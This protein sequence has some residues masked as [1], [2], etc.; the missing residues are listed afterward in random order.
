V[1]SEMLA[2]ITPELLT[3]YPDQREL[4]RKL[5]QFTSLPEDSLLLTAGSDSA[6]KLVYE[7]F[8]APGDEVVFLEP[9]YAMIEVYADLFEARKQKVG[10]TAQLDLRF[11]ELLERITSKTRVAF[12]ANPNQPSGTVLRN[13]QL[14]ELLERTS[15]TGTLLVMDEAYQHFS[16]TPSALELV[17]NHDNLVVTQTFSKAFGLA[18]VRLGFLAA[19]PAH[20]DQ[21][22]K[23]KPL[24]DINLL[25]VKCGEY[26][27]DHY[28]PI[29]GEYVRSVRQAKV[30]LTR[31]LKT[32]G[33][34]VIPSEANFI[35]FRLGAQD[36]AGRIAAR[37]KERGYLIRTA[38]TGLPAV[39]EGCI[40]ITVGPLEQMKEFL[41][42]FFQVIQKRI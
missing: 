21:L 2:S 10:Y 41:T 4:Y 42:T 25:A 19:H 26:L 6:I 31:E 36:D 28:D 15:S 34:Q 1:V 32:L 23:S 37:M 13:G 17:K 40:R 20:I 38:G 30:Y 35:H 7:T 5:S 3:A 16:A 29:V 18:S 24:C 11:D 12:I 8:V 27:L 22:Y 14:E 9:T 33:I 39:L